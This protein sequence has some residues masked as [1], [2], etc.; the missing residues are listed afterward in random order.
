MDIDFSDWLLEKMREH[1][2]SQSD[3]S[4]ATG[5]TRQSIS[6]YIS[7]K[8]KQPDE[9][10]LQ[11]IAKALSLPIAEVYR[12]AGTLPPE[13]VETKLIRQITHLT[14][15]LPPEEQQGI[16]EFIKLRLRLSEERGKYETRK[17][18]KQSGTSK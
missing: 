18:A 15:Q 5:L 4:R 12:A 10:A 13:P 3:L 7:G 17:P 14:T 2:W 1:D 8:S 6:Y 16:L 11:K 9:F